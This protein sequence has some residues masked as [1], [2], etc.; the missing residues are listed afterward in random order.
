L[1]G[2]RQQLRSVGR[3]A[4]RLA[5][6]ASG[7]SEG[8]IAIEER[9]G[10]SVAFRRGTAD[11]K[12]LEQSFANDIFFAAVPDYTPAPAD[13]ILDVGAH[14][15]AFA[16]EAARKAPQGRVHAIEAA[17]E[18][19]NL[20]RINVALNALPNV[21]TSHLALAGQRGTVTLHHDLAGNWGHSIVAPL[22]SRTEQVEADTLENFLADRRIDK[23]DFAK[24]NCEGAEFPILLASPAT[25]LARIERLLI[26]FHCD[27]ATGYTLQQLTGALADAGFQLELRANK[28]QRGRIIARRRAT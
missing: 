9:G 2:L 25:T 21:E 4:T 15:G 6:A 14:I 13:V 20:L 1:A 11:E 23:V 8:Q 17:E 5:R 18:N 27:L 7:R 19:C 22:S 10:F 12:V 26:F 3:A 28:K 24:F 16:I